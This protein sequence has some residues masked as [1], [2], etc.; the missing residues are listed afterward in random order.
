MPPLITVGKA[1][2]Y[3]TRFLP[4]RRRL[5]LHTNDAY[6]TVLNKILLFIFLYGK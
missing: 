2:R 5:T 1:I 3:A 4:S 6:G